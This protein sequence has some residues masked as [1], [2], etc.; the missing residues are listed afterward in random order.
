M[1]EFLF[2]KLLEENES[3]MI[4]GEKARIIDMDYA[5]TK[6]G[7]SVQVDEVSFRAS[8]RWFSIKWF[9]V[10]FPW[11][12]YLLLVI[13]WREVIRQLSDFDLFQWIISHQAIFVILVILAIWNAYKWLALLINRTVITADHQKMIVR[14]QP[15]PTYGNRAFQ[16]ENITQLFIAKVVK[17]TLP[18][19]LVDYYGPILRINRKELVFY[20]LNALCKD[21]VARGI[22]IGAEY[23]VVHYLE[24]RL[25]DFWGITD[26]QVEGEAEDISQVEQALMNESIRNK[27]RDL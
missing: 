3:R 9:S 1:H 20:Q 7:L 6:S 11:I 4:R 16:T 24:L 12:Y 22:L 17:R 14:H 18:A 10:Y 25:E 23:E 15:L 19:L 21:K 5:T 13:F 8:F 27:Y 2:L 26:R